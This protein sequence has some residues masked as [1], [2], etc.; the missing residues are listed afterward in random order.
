MK[1]KTTRTFLKG[2]LCSAII[3]LLAVPLITLSAS[4]KEVPNTQDTSP[5]SWSPEA[6]QEAHKL[7]AERDAAKVGAA[8][9]SVAPARTKA[10]ATPNGFGVVVNATAG[11]TGPTMLRDARRGV[12]RD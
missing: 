9:T 6:A 2:T 3:A 8:T 7:Q 10:P 12:R 11:T 1:T 4:Q 5:S